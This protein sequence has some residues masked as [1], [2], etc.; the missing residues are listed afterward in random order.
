MSPKTIRFH[1]KVFKARHAMGPKV[2]GEALV[3][4]DG[5]SARYDL[6]RIKG[7]FSRPAHKLAGQSYVG[8][9]LVLDTSKGGVASAWMLA[10]MGSRDKVPLAIVFNTVNPILVQGAAFGDI[11]MLA[12]FDEDVTALIPSGATVE[13]DPEKKTLRVL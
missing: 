5:F 7:V 11:T 12:G 1:P 3:A 9:V 6:D 8:K 13:I 2:S 4:S 10:E